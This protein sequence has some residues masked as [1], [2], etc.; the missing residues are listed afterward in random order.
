[1]ISKEEILKKVN[2]KHQNILAAILKDDWSAIEA[3]ACSSICSGDEFK[4]LT[5]V[6]DE[7]IGFN[8]KGRRFWCEQT[9]SIGLNTKERAIETVHKWERGE[10][11]G[12]FSDRYII[13]GKLEVNDDNLTYE[14]AKERGEED[15]WCPVIE[16]VG[17]LYGATTDLEPGKKVDDLVLTYCDDWIKKI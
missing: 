16:I 11:V 6:Y 2:E 10:N 14:E 12:V 15:T 4:D 17:W 1:M 8:Y 7:S 3:E 5:P 9:V 13:W